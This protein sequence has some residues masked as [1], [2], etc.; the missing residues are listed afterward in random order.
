MKK[1]S[2]WFLFIFLIAAFPAYGKTLTGNWQVDAVLT[3]TS[4]PT[5]QV[6]EG[7]RKVDRWQ[8]K[9]NGNQAVLTGQAGS[10][11]GVYYAS[12]P[13]FPGGV[14]K[15]EAVVHNLMNQPNLSAKFEIVIVQRSANVI[16]GGFTTTY[17][18]INYGGGPMVPLGLESWR[19]DGTRLN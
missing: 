16:S 3:A 6:K 12:T 18:G 1:Q 8:I 10:I 17:L 14:W 9:Q 13:E 7:F 5:P 4:T 15:F 19:F 2:F 11:S